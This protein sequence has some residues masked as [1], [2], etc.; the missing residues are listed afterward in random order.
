MEAEAVA[1][2]GEVEEA[3]AAVVEADTAAAAAVI[4]MAAVEVRLSLDLIFMHICA[5]YTYVRKRTK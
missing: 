5:Y 4:V 3:T 2:T 1:T